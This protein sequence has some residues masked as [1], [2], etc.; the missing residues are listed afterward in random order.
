MKAFISFQEMETIIKEKA[1][2]EIKLAFAGTPDTIKVD[3]TMNVK[4][5]LLGTKSKDVHAF[6]TLNRISGFDLDITYALARGMDFVLDLLTKMLNK[7]IE[8]IDLVSVGQNSNNLILHCDKIVQKAGVKDFHKIEE[9]VTINALHVTDSGIEA[10]F[11]L[12]L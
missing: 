6:L 9:S 8:K 4:V 7:D 10:E 3:Y 12:K 1:R 2:K 5:P 11:S